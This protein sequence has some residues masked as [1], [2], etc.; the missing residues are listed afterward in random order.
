MNIENKN[1]SY[2]SED[3]EKKEKLLVY[4]ESIKD[5]GFSWIYRGEGIHHDEKV[6]RTWKANQHLRG[7]WFSERFDIAEDF[8][9][10][11][12]SEGREAYIYSLMIPNAILEERS[13]L[14]KNVNGGEINIVNPDLLNS[15]IETATQKNNE[16]ITAE[17]YLDQFEY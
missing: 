10:K 11:E 4:V 2:N 12:E 5:K 15:K 1:T 7:T 13:I 14:E 16:E 8:K 17:M 3:S 9:N 6:S